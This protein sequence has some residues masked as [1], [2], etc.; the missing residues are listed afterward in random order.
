MV[1]LELGRYREAFYRGT[2][3]VPFR[4]RVAHEFVLQDDVFGLEEL[5]IELGIS[6]SVRK[7]DYNGDS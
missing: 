5:G 4:F 7:F 3:A 1:T 2:K 6:R